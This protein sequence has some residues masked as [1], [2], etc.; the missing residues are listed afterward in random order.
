MVIDVKAIFIEQFTKLFENFIWLLP[1]LFVFALYLFFFRHDISKD[2][3]LTRREKNKLTEKSF[4][5]I[6]LILGATVAYLYIKGYYF[7][8]AIV[9]SAIV[10]YILYLV[11][12]IN[13][14]LQK[15]ER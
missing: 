13:M 3:M 1:V 6:I 5:A 10:I 9:A 12:I 11:G 14:V 2:F 4:L 8:L 7:L 15:I